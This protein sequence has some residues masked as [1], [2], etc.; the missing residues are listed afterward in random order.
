[1]P[2]NWDTQLVNVDTDSYPPA[3]LDSAKSGF[4]ASTAGFRFTV[5][6]PR[7]YADGAAPLVGGGPALASATITIPATATTSEDKT[8]SNLPNIQMARIDSTG[9]GINGIA[10]GS[11]FRQDLTGAGGLKRYTGADLCKSQLSVDFLFASLTTTYSK[12]IDHTASGY[13]YV[14]A[15]MHIIAA[16]E[17]YGDTFKTLKQQRLI[18]DTMTYKFKFQTTVTVAATATVTY[19]AIDYSVVLTSSK[20]RAPIPGDWTALRGVKTAYSVTRHATGCT[21]ST[22]PATWCGNMTEIRLDIGVTTVTPKEYVTTLRTSVDASYISTNVN[23]FPAKD[24]FRISG[25]DFYSGVDWINND[26]KTLRENGLNTQAQ[27]AATLDGTPG[28]FNTGTENTSGCQST[29]SGGHCKQKYR[30]YLKYEF[31]QNPTAT[32]YWAP[33]AAKITSQGYG[34]FDASTNLNTD[35]KKC[36]L[37]GVV[38]NVGNGAT[39]TTGTS[40]SSEL[41]CRK[42]LTMDA[43]SGYTAGAHQ[44][45]LTTADH[46]VATT[47]FQTTRNLVAGSVGAADNSCPFTTDGGDIEDNI[48][49]EIKITTADWCPALAIDNG[50]DTG[51]TTS[52]TTFFAD[53]Q[54]TVYAHAK[55]SGTGGLAPT[56]LVWKELLGKCPT[57]AGPECNV[58]DGNTPGSAASPAHLFL[59][60]NYDVD[61]HT[62]NAA[63]SG[64][65]GAGLPTG[66]KFMDL[67]L[68][69]TPNPSAGGTNCLTSG[70]TLPSGWSATGICSVSASFYLC[71]HSNAM[72][73]T[74]TCGSTSTNPAFDIDNASSSTGLT[75][76]AVLS[77][78]FPSV[79]A[80]TSKKTTRVEYSPGKEVM[81]SLLQSQSEDAEVALDVGFGPRPTAVEESVEQPEAETTGA[82]NPVVEE[83][84]AVEESNSMLIYIIVG[85]FLFI[86]VFVGALVMYLRRSKND[87]KVHP[88]PITVEVNKSTAAMA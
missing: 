11:H 65:S 9:D 25:K 49:A 35:N 69:P 38:I 12:T 14:Y 19:A 83:A 73:A 54:I 29:S 48:S 47:T 22:D 40:R 71:E 2:T 30:L 56:Q 32:N 72:G 18:V 45:T 7:Q 61:G 52:K 78:G 28:I 21:A 34:T 46:G 60:Y 59:M 33:A 53:E 44:Y 76:S 5:K 6:I 26:V 36:Q 66:S 57:A 75:F 50:L 41:H 43:A 37:K 55:A 42:T 24:G 16:T 4:L 64:S 74:T 3:E 84:A 39:L 27:I 86:S 79:D 13:K 17:I 63:P 87:K 68:I 1:M 88:V 85:V 10:N 70:V 77:V 80:A 15:A 8:Y 58:L 81:Y 82:S 62:H 31:I 51:M 67:N 23:P 20:V